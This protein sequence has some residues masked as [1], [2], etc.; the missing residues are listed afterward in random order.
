[1]RELGEEQV[2]DRPRGELG[3]A[4][5]AGRLQLAVHAQRPLIEG[6]HELQVRA[7]EERTN[8]PVDEFRMRVRD[9]R[10]DPHDD[11]AAQHVQALPQRLAFAD[12]IAG[13]GK[14]L[15]VDVDR[16]A[17]LPRDVARAVLGIRVD[18]DDLVDEREALHQAR[19]DRADDA[20]HRGLFVQRGQADRD[21]QPLTLLRLDQAPQV[22]E[23]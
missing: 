20:A 9:V 16:Y 19:A 12:V 21:G 2:E 4:P 13:A 14:D 22:R 1:P 7:H 17:L 11:V 5:A 10:I 18:D 8:D 15:A 6:L 3:D 23:L